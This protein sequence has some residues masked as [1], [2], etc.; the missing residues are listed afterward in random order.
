[1]SR[2]K[3]TPAREPVASREARHL[4]AV[5]LDVLAGARTPTQAAEAL[6]LSLP[7]YYQL[8]ARAVGGLIG[9]CE[10]R[11]RGRQVEVTAEL[12]RANKEV[13]R[14]KRELSRAKG[15]DG[16]TPA[17]RFFG[18]SEEVK[19][20]LAARVAANALELARGGVP[21]APFYLTGQA[22]GQPF[23]VHA[24]DGRVIL[25]NPDGRQ[26]ID[27]LPRPAEAPTLPVPVCPHGVVATDGDGFE[28]PPAPGTSPL[29]EGL[30]R[31]GDG[32]PAGEG[33]AP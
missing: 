22:G 31:L 20:A 18:A 1:M 5:I 32:A 17:D 25:T 4:A 13:D 10:P 21:K 11:P 3:T 30:A 33:G 2:P 23:S 14:L 24:E 9:A 6:S 7:R 26:E 15:I 27:L 8:E 29:D 19:R 16:A 12:T 28:E